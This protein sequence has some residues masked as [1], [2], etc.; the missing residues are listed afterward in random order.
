MDRV[1]I[2]FIK[3]QK[4]KKKDDMEESANFHKGFSDSRGSNNLTNAVI[5]SFYHEQTLV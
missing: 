2:T 5:V 1:S 3:L 4:R